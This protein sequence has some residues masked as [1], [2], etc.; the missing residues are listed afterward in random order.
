MKK[1]DAYIV[2]L[3]MTGASSLFFATITT[4]NMVYQATVVGLNPLQLV[5]VGTV[6]ELSAFFCEV[7]TGIV[8]DI[9]SRRLSVIVG[10]ALTGL[11]FVIEGTIPRFEAVLLAQV[12]WGVGHTFISG[13]GEAWIADEIGE[14]EA[15]PA[16]LRGAQVG[17]L[18]GL[19][20]IGLSVALASV[21]VQLPIV[22]GGALYVGLAFFL[23]LVMP[24]NGFTPT[25][26][27]DRNSW[28]QM[29]ETARRS[30]RLVRG[31]PALMTVMGLSLVYGLYS[32]G[33]DRLWTPHL[34]ENF[35]LPTFGAFQ[36]V[37]WFGI[38]SAVGML[39][40][41][42]TVELVR[43]RVDTNNRRA[44]PMA[45]SFLYSLI[46]LGTVGLALTGYFPLALAGLWTI[47]VARR[48]SGPLF[49]AW[50]NQN[51]ESTVRAT[52]ISAY[53]Q[54]NALGQIVGGP[55][56]GAIGTLYSLRV[57]LTVSGLALT[58]TLWLFRRSLHQST[59][60]PHP[61]PDVSPS[62]A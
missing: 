13:A 39:L 33:F 55:I 49:T 48:S 27:T 19:A 17:Q 47:Q 46:S 8:A 31:R 11:G 1:L 4:V 5:L 6:L 54:L 35:T 57:A 21:Y 12:V 7:P 25:P 16:Y 50:I 23:L 34:L 58:P 61:D 59:A 28:Q 36:P 60:L 43:R 53:S 22:I 42:A 9:Y 3:V 32:E 18:T 14:R 56:V 41:I 45:L 51:V 26:P 2:Y 15:G 20:G 30:T 44:V 29:A 37:V 24:E 40:S 62:E 38:I 10:F 52:V